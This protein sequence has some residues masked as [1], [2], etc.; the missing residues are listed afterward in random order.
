MVIGTSV[1][2]DEALRIIA[3]LFKHLKTSLHTVKHSLKH[4]KT[5]IKHHETPVKHCEML[6]AKL[7]HS[8]F[9]EAISVLG[10]AFPVLVELHGQE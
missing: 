3:R 8:A 7:K 4:H 10:V 1:G 6:E 5:L 2:A 9:N